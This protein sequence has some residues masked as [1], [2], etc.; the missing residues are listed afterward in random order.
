LP[1]GILVVVN[2]AAPLT[3]VAVPSTSDPL[4]KVTEPVESLGS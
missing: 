1:T 3:R 2:E 4:L